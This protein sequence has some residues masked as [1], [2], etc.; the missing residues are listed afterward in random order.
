MP[1][2][3]R[4]HLQRAEPNFDLIHRQVPFVV[5]S[6][7]P[8]KKNEGRGS[9]ALAL[10][11]NPQWVTTTRTH[12]Y[13]LTKDSAAGT[14]PARHYT[15]A[16]VSL[17]IPGRR[18]HVPLGLEDDETRGLRSRSLIH[19]CCTVLCESVARVPHRPRCSHGR[20]PRGYSGHSLNLKG[21]R[22]L[23]N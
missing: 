22:Y 14:S 15:T 12:F 6:G 3:H 18:L 8:G 19:P 2:G 17:K 13:R 16:L 11:G 9:L 21:E 10:V 1:A 7:P 20:L 4:L 23:S 5:A